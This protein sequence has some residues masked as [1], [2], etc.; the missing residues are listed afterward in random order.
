[1]FKPTAPAKDA[2]AATAEP[3]A[4]TATAEPQA[5]HAKS[6]RRK[7]GWRE[8][9]ESIVIAF[10]L[11]FLFRTFEA[12]AFVIPTGSMAPTLYGRHKDITCTKCGNHFAVG[13]SDEVP[14]DNGYLRPEFR[15]ETAICPNCRYEMDIRDMQPFKGDRILVTKFSY[16]IGDPQRWDVLV[17]KYPEDPKTNYIKR[18]VGLPG[19]M[20]K[21]EGGDVFAR[22]DA[23]SEWRILR[24]DDPNKQRQLQL[25]VYDN[26]RPERELH[27]LGWPQRWAAVT[28]G[29]GASAARTDTFG[30]WKEDSDGW[31][32]DQQARSFELNRDL[33]ANGDFRW[34]RYRH[35]VP[36]PSDWD[37]AEQG[38]RTLLNPRPSLVSDYCSYNSYTG[39]SNP[40]GSDNGYFWTGDLTLNC[41]VEILDAGDDGQI[42]LELVEGLR[43]YRCR[44]DLTTGNAALSVID[45]V[46]TPDDPEER[47]LA[48]ASTELRGLGAFEVTFANVDDRLC[49]WVDGTLVDFGGDAEYDQPALSKPTERDLTPVG[50]AARGAR[51]RV[52]DL[53]LERDIYYRAE[54]IDQ[55]GPYGRDLAKLL[56]QPEEWYQEYKATA[57]PVVFEALGKDEFFVMGDNSPRS[58]DSRLWENTRGAARRHAVPRTALVGKAFYIYWPHGVP[59]MNDGRGYTVSYHKTGPGADD[60]TDYPSVTVPF[61]PN[62]PRMHRIR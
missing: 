7:D 43:W 57:E 14:D 8:T 49:L 42:L 41:R 32:A 59:F 54:K 37:L 45:G 15:L 28:P 58:K 13:A 51:V 50:I 44:I 61:Y 31:T 46:L 52:S 40:H 1:M 21:I 24:K 4:E 6:A 20:L 62:I 36:A 27:E 16:E 9:F 34:L 17:F 33:T 56:S 25:L 53:L 60:K 5:T 10:I 35:I 19:E 48:T 23:T 12:E 11:A 55:P 47:E 3:P 18:L 30:G 22:A 39:G 38:Q 2:A 29:S 26:N